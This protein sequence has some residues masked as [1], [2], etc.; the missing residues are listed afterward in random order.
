MTGVADP[1]ALSRVACGFVTADIQDENELK[2][3]LNY[4]AYP[5]FSHRMGHRLGQG[6]RPWQLLDAWRKVQLVDS[7]LTD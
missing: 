7:I 5:F 4:G 2:T 1:N 3:L 6:G